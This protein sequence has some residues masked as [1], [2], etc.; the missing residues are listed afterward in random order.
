MKLQIRQ[1]Y[2]VF[3]VMSSW[4]KSNGCFRYSKVAIILDNWA[5]HKSM[6][7]RRIL[8]EIGCS[9][10]FIPPYSPD[11]APIEYCFSIVKRKLSELLNKEQGLVQIK[12][13]YSKLYDWLTQIKSNIIKKMFLKFFSTIK[14]IYRFIFLL[15]KYKNLT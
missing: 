7:T 6:A 11:F 2:L 15:I 8:Q 5:I 9:V 4:L 13:N 12:N 10:F 3:K 14:K 1:I